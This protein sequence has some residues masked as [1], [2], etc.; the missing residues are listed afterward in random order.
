MK[1]VLLIAVGVL[2]AAV[3]FLLFVPP[4]IDLGAYK[5][6]YLPLVEE[7]LQRKVDVGEVRLRIL[8]APSV[9]VS[10]LAVSDNPAFS[11]ESFFAAQHFHLKL[12]FWPLLQGQFQVD[13]FV[14]E[15]PLLKLIKRPDG[16]FN[17]ADIG[18]GKE[19]VTKRE[20]RPKGKEPAKLSGIIPTKVRIEEG[21]VT[22]QTVGQKP[23]KIQGVDL[24]FNDFSTDQPFPYRVALMLAGL[25]PISL[26][27]R[28]SYDESRS[29][30]SLRE[31]HLKVQDVDIAVSGSIADLTGVPRV[32]LNLANDGFETKPIFQLLSATGAIPKDTEIAGPLGLK[33]AMTGPSN[34]LASQVNVE[35]KGLKVN[36]RRSFQGTVVGKT[37]LSFL[38]GG[39]APLVRTLRGNGNIAVKDGALTNVDLISKIKEITG[40][41]GL[42]AEQ[43][44]GATTF[45]NLETDFTL[46]QGVADLKRIYL[47]SPAMEGNGSGKMTLASP[48]LD[49]S[50]EVALSPHISARAGSGKAATFLKDSRGRIVVPL[51]I[52]GPV[53]K[54]SVSIDSG[55][56]V[57]KGVDRL[58]ERFF[59]RR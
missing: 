45:K 57:Q 52:K 40:L 17:F 24:S 41:I 13:E 25:K 30:L 27:G 38:L 43:R 14:L 51:K 23:L 50:L 39:E 54:P 48:S 42:P 18:K 26:E 56:A 55:K 32:N 11:K 29:T 58:F 9:R 15:K 12:K 20:G 16:I 19:T 37:F 59:R 31:N 44:Q 4:F 5:A 3:A 6:R 49:L 8:P 33:V 10:A 22:L 2:A 47:D 53:Q 28:L 36:G 35:F 7:A 34:A 46:G 1:K 21:E